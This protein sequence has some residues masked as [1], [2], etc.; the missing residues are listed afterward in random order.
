MRLESILEV[1]ARHHGYYRQGKVIVVGARG[2]PLARRDSRPVIA[3]EYHEYMETAV[4]TSERKPV[5]YA[6]AVTKHRSN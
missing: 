3:T 2:R 6:Y 4:L 5:S 1:M